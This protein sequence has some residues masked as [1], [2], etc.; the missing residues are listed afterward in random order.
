M[1]KIERK[2]IKFGGSRGIMLPP[3]WRTDLKRVLISG[4]EKQL[5]ISDLE[6]TSNLK[7]KIKRIIAERVERA[8]K[9]YDEGNLNFEKYLLAKIE[10]FE[11]A[12]R[13]VEEAGI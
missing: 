3:G 12:L 9:A 10:G 1:L 13:M 5:H 4:D 2:I 7:D 6:R 11:I 8:N